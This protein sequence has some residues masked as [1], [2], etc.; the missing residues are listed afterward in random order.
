PASPEAE[1]RVGPGRSSRETKPTRP[2]ACLAAKRECASS[3]DTLSDGSSSGLYLALAETAATGVPHPSWQG[4]KMTPSVRTRRARPGK[5]ILKSAG[6]LG[7]QLKS[8]WE[9]R[10]VQQLPEQGGNPPHFFVR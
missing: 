9:I 4:K 8:R 1:A 5:Q 10:T 3:A 6:V 7:R 2:T